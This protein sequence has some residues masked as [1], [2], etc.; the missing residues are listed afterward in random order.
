MLEEP[1]ILIIDE[2]DKMDKDDMSVLLSLME[3]GL[4]TKKVHDQEIRLRLDTRVYAACNYV[5]K[6]PK[7]LRS[8]FLILSFR[9]Y[10]RE[11]FLKVS[12]PLLVDR[13]GVDENL[14]KYIAESLVSFTRDVRDAIKVARLA[15]SKEDVDRIVSI[16]KKSKNELGI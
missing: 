7:E 2:L 16:M 11:E 14:A 10:T 13:E 5:H 1:T 12:I 9:P 15:K 3:S 8:R 6:L 4:V